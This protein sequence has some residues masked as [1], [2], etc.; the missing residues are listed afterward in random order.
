LPFAAGGVH[1]SGLKPAGGFL[2][3]KEPP[4]QT[5]MKMPPSQAKVCSSPTVLMSIRAIGVNITPPKPRAETMMPV[6]IP[7]LSGN[8]FWQQAIRVE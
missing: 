7:R 5:T 4:T 1:P 6:I 3:K 8:H 2:T